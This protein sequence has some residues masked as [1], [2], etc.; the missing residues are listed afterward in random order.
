MCGITG[1]FD[2]D[3]AGGGSGSHSL[4]VL[5]RMNSRLIHRG[6]D[7]AGYFQSPGVNLAMRR[8]KVIDLSG[9]AQPIFNEDKTVVVV[10]N[11]EIYN[12]RELR[13][14]LLAGGHRFV[15]DSDTEVLVHLYEASGLEMAR[16]LRGM[17]AFA[18]WDARLKRL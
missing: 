9:G 2:F 12:Y 5:R 7:D 1:F 18:I 11:G 14:E 10:F 17:F 4:E 13:Q 3:R 6:P 8:L 15:T 16:C